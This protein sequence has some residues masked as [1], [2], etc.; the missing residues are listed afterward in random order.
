MS[1]IGGKFVLFS[2]RACGCVGR[3]NVYNEMNRAE[4]ELFFKE[5]EREVERVL[6][7]QKEAGFF[8]G[9]QGRGEKESEGRSD[10]EDE[11]WLFVS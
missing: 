2:C 8:D 9:P 3:E 4:R 5:S 6:K 7:A 1:C 10:G 11:G